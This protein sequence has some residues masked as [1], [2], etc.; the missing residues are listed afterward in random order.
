MPTT[1]FSPLTLWAVDFADSSMV[2][3]DKFDVIFRDITKGDSD[4][5][6]FCNSFFRWTHCLDDLV[7]RDQEVPASA[8]AI[9]QYSIFHNL[10]CNPFFQKHKA[11][12]LPTMLTASIAWAD[13]E[14]WKKRENVLHRISSQVLKSQYQD[15]FIHV[16]ALCG[17]QVHAHQ[18]SNRYRD[19]NFDNEKDSSNA[20]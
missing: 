20:G 4:A 2:S 12:L 9:L 19:Y 3:F 17:G 13:S 8:V 10:A 14:A 7:D 5:F 16:A 1:A 18:M 15:V 11:S 6:D